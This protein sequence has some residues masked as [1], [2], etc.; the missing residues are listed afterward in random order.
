MGRGVSKI[1]AGG[2][3][4]TKPKSQL[5]I[6]IENLENSIWHGHGKAVHPTSLKVGDRI[7]GI[8]YSF[9][10]D[11]L[12]PKQNKSV[13][14]GNYNGIPTKFKADNTFK[15]TSIKS[16]NKTTEI[17]AERLGGVGGTVKK[18]IPNNVYLQMF[19]N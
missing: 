15:I 1:G 3:G 6:Q 12:V 7:S 4:A 5:D 19:A 13:W 8:Q 14:S 9:E 16:D 17:S 10:P 18:K 2:G 11:V